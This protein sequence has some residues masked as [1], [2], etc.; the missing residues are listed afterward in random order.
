M[1]H[2]VLPANTPCLHFHRKRS[3]DGATSNWGKRHPIAAY[4]SSIDP[5]G[6]KSWVGLVGCPYRT[7]YPHKWSLVSCRSRAGQ[8]KYAGE[9]PTFYHCAMQPAGD[10]KIHWP[11][12]IKFNRNTFVTGESPIISLVTT[13]QLQGVLALVSHGRPAACA[14][15]MMKAV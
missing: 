12:W 6:M 5:E 11:Y 15:A 3:P 9:R 13:L 4:Y 7:V 8:R 1:D 10:S 2:T 14:E